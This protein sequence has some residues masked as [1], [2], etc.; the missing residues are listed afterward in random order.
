MMLLFKSRESRP[1]LVCFIRYL[2]L[3]F[4]YPIPRVIALAIL[5][6]FRDFHTPQ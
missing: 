6:I 1:L 5:E 2:E 4:S 3:S